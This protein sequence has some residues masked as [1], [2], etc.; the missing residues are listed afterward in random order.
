MAACIG[1]G[2]AA[3]IADILLKRFAFFDDGAF[4]LHAFNLGRTGR[5]RGV[6]LL[7]VAPA[8][9]DVLPIVAVAH[10]VLSEIFPDI[11]AGWFSRIGQF[12]FHGNALE[13]S[14]L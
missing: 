10:T 4:A 3:W 8:R 14:T 2:P 7:C 6:R 9:H 12:I 11:S 13:Q 5:R 1:A